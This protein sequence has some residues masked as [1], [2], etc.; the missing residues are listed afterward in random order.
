MENFDF[1]SILGS[2]S[3]MLGGV[4]F[5]ALLNTFMETA[6]KLIEMLKPL[7]E[8]LSSGTTTTDPATTA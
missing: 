5:Q 2:L 4:D 6:K 1:N 3:E 7:L 8:N